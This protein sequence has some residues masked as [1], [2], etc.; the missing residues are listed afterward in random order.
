MM[1]PRLDETDFTM[2]KEVIINEIARS[3]DQPYNLTYRR[4]MQDYS[5]DHP[6]GH[7]VLGS[8]ESIRNLG[9]EQMRDYWKRRYAANNLVLSIAGNSTGITL[10]NWQNNIAATG[11]PAIVDAM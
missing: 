1:Y 9:I 8:R 2:E 3:E 7:D 6:L 4:M 10:S 5:I 11:V